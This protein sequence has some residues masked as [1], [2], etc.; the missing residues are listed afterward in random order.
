M[1]INFD[2]VLYVQLLIIYMGKLPTIQGKLL[3]YHARNRRLYLFVQ[4]MPRTTIKTA[5][6]KAVD[7]CQLLDGTFSFYNPTPKTR[8]A[9]YICMYVATFRI[10]KVFLSL[11]GEST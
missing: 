2:Y 9:L 8:D 11:R 4:L 7:V 1:K 3:F 6:C 10:P 5:F